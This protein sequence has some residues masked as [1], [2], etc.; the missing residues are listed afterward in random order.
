MEADQ[1]HLRFP[2]GR[3]HYRPGEDEERR[4]EYLDAIRE[5]PARMRELVYGATPAQ[6]ATPYRPGGWT[7]REV[8]H[9]VAD[10]HMNAF[11]RF[12]LALTEEV[13][14]IKPYL[15]PAWARLPDTVHTPPETSVALLTALHERWIVLMTHMKADDW[16]CALYHPEQGRQITLAEFLALY[17]WHGEHHLGHLRLVMK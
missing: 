17:A 1:E 12:K 5:L 15:Q 16:S 2:I 13:P 4:A 14:T 6:W 3:F 9:H 7:S 11:I 10:S 8:V